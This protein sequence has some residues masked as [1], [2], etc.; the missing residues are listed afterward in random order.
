MK[1]GKH[2]W[3]PEVALFYINISIIFLVQGF[4]WDYCLR[5]NFAG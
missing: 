5:F 3:P 4:F 2:S 1:G